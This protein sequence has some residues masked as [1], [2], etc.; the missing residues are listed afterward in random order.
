MRYQKTGKK[1]YI[2]ITDKIRRGE[3][4]WGG[5]TLLTRHNNMHSLINCVP[6]FD[7]SQEITG[8]LSKLIL[9]SKIKYIF[10]DPSPLFH[11]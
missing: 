9:I 10:K 3:V 6:Y 1:Q 5:A 8:L 4:E 11:S 2:L 7:L